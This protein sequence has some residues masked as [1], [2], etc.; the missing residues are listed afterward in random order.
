METVNARLASLPDLLGYDSPAALAKACGIDP[1]TLR[2]AMQGPSKPSFDVLEALTA[3]N[4]KLSL[5]WLMH[6]TG[7]MLRD[8]RALTPRPAEPLPAQRH[9][10]TSGPGT[11]NTVVETLLRELLTNK[12]AVIA[13]KNAVIELQAAELSELRGKPF[14]SS[15][16]A[17][18]LNEAPVDPNAP[19]FAGGNAPAPA[20]RVNR[21][22]FKPRFLDV[23]ELS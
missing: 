16:A 10:Y 19:T 12:D 11:V 8:G 20:L 13:S 21:A 18:A 14:D 23:A 4:P 7:P 3:K 22:G 1:N 2:K 17:D 9:D 6:G 5:D 15:D